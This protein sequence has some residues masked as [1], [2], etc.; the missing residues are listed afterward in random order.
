VSCVEPVEVLADSRRGPIRRRSPASRGIGEKCGLSTAGGFEGVSLE[1][2]PREPAPLPK[3]ASLA[4]GCPA[5]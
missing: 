1:Q 5:P 4:R 2:T 3:V